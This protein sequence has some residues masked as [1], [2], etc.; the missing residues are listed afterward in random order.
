MSDPADAWLQTLPPKRREAL[1]AVLHA[2]RAGL[3]DGYAERVTDRGISWNVPH[4]ICPDGYHCDASAPVPF[5]GLANNKA[6]ASLHLFGIYVMGDVKER[7]VEA[8]Q[9]S[10][11]KLDMGASCVR[12]TS[13]ARVPLD[14]VTEAIAAMPVDAFLA[15]YEASLPDK[16]RAKRGRG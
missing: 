15:R 13:A 14:V 4:S 10:G 8:W 6:K 3:P 7:F 9:A 2:V 5:A 1:T 11:H 16:V 12:F